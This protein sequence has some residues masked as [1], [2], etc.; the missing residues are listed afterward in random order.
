MN[1]TV[2]MIMRI[3]TALLWPFNT[4]TVFIDSELITLITPDSV[5]TISCFDS[6]HSAQ[7]DI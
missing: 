2:F 1:I 7:S 6:G 3:L 5:P 4:P